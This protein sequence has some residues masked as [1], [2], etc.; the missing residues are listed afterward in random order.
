M[1]GKLL[2]ISVSR[3]GQLYGKV[4]NWAVNSLE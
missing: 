4:L 2:D 1:Y 3:L